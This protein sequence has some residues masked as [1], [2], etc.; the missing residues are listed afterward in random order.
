VEL[1]A[2]TLRRLWPEPAGGVDA[3]GA[4]SGLGLGDLAPP[5]RPYLVLNMVA[6]ADGKATIE[7]RTGALGNEADRVVFHHLR[8]QVDAVLVGAGTVR[9]ERYGRIVKH[10]ALREKRVREGLDPDP[11]ALVVSARLDLSTDIPLLAD[12]ESRVVILTSSD[13]ELPGCRAQ[14]EYLRPPA[15]ALAPETDP[16]GAPRFR[17]GPL[18]ERLREERGVRS[19]LCEGGPTLNSMLLEEGVVDELFLC[20]APLLAGGTGAPT[21]VEGLPLQQPAAMEIG[22]AYESESHLLLRYRLKPAG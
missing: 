9:V 6:T 16:G 19:V 17:V 18:L 5:G 14:V 7:G 15:E 12:P 10:P 22:W 11:L 1:P 8:S 2:V 13:A 4:I 21:I 3:A 20:L